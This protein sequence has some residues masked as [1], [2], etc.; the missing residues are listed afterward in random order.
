MIDSTLYP[1][2][3]DFLVIREDAGIK[4]RGLYATKRLKKGSTLVRATPK[5]AIF[6]LLNLLHFCSHCGHAA[7]DATKTLKQ[8]TGCRAVQYCGAACQSAAWQDVH[9]LECRALKGYAS[10]N[11]PDRPDLPVAVP[12]TPIRALA[13]LLWK[14]SLHDERWWQPIAALQSRGLALLRERFPLTRRRQE[15][16]APGPAR[17]LCSAG[18]EALRLHWVGSHHRLGG[19]RRALGP[20]LC[21]EFGL[22]LSLPLI[23]V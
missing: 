22:L 11:K 18:H 3:P 6:D 17:V 2:L 8:C 23:P 10:K 14:R 9:K 20:L 5:V 1:E 21:C 19:A 12:E 7:D 13:Q 4:A 16:T 15:A